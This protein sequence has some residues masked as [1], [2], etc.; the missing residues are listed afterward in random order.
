MRLSFEQGP[1]PPIGVTEL[2]RTARA[3]AA[4]GAWPEVRSLLADR[5][6]ERE[7]APELAVY[8]AKAEM[9][10]GNPRAAHA[11][12]VEYIP[13]LSHGES[14]ALRRAV[15]LLGIAHFVLGDIDSAEQ[16]FGQALD[17]AYASGDLLMVARVMNNLGAVQNLRGER[18]QALTFYRLATPAYERLDYLTGRAET[19]HNMAMTYRELGHLTEAEA[20][21]R[22]A[23]ALAR[24]AREPRVERMARVGLAE[25][26]LLRGNARAADRR[27]TRAAVACASGLDPVGEADALRLVGAARAALGAV[28]DA[29]AALDRAISLARHH[30]APLIEA[31]AYRV[32]ATLYAN[33]GMASQAEKDTAAADAIFARMKVMGR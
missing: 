9:R 32:R 14:E 25:L 20:S 33:L 24:A 16:A 30:G 1:D 4:A 21:E 11:L 19:H 26:A 2:L 8:L 27:A 10:L 29:L 31:E 12:L 17:Q 18:E 28:D 22:Q 7:Q 5:A 23:L 15:N 6:R 13:A 3:E